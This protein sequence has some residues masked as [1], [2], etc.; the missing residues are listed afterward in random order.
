M[1]LLRLAPVCQGIDFESVIFLKAME[2]AGR[3][4][5]G[6]LNSNHMAFSALYACQLA[7]GR[8]I[9]VV[10]CES[11]KLRTNPWV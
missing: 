5:H 2:L 9:V 7:L 8:G 10:T 4:T 6:P 11:S 3:C 1:G